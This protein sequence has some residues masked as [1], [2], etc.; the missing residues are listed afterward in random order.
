M[1]AADDTK[2]ADPCVFNAHTMARDTKR[3]TPRNLSLTNEAWRQA[4]KLADAEKRSRTNLIE[5][6]IAREFERLSKEAA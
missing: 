2:L 4:G 3:K 1:F 6:L 5:S